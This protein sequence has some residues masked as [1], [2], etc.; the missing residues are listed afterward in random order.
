[1]PAEGRA[2]EECT[3]PTCA[4]GSRADL[5][6]PVHLELDATDISRLACHASY[7]ITLDMYAGTLDRARQAN[8]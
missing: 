7:G 1:M 4:A 6:A 3:L 8:R 5:V 2:H